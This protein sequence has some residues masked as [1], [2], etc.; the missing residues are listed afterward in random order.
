MH[1]HTHKNSWFFQ[2]VHFFLY[3]NSCWWVT[4]GHSVK[5]FITEL[6]QYCCI[7]FT[8]SVFV[9]HTVQCR[10]CCYWKT[11]WI[12]NKLPTISFDRRKQLHRHT[13]VSFSIHNAQSTMKITRGWDTHESRCLEKAPPVGFL[14]MDDIVSYS[15]G[16]CLHSIWATSKDKSVI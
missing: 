6:L 16:F 2:K 9:G 11:S 5:A 7:S 14:E 13:W 15:W 12:R 4:A 1:T 3:A 8:W 10:K